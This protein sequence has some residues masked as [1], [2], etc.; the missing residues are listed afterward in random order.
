[1]NKAIIFVIEDDP[2]AQAGIRALLDDTHD[3]A[4]TKAPAESDIEQSLCDAK[5]D[6][7]LFGLHIT[8]TR[9]QFLLRKIALQFRVLVFSDEDETLH[10][11]DTLRAGA[12]GYIMK[13]E[14]PEILLKA[15]RTTLAGNLHLSDK[16]KSH[17]FQR[18]AANGSA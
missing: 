13:E 18:I 10:A 2:L 5:P 6:L 11:E 7:V 15:I 3:L 16:M 9:N 1:M 12:R 17:F 4:F 8:K 14:S